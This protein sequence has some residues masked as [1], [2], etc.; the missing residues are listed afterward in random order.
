MAI[1]GF[2]FASQTQGCITASIHAG[3][4]APANSIHAG[5]LSH[6]ISYIN[7]IHKTVYKKKLEYLRILP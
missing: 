3:S 6:E 1:L 4:A 2:G 5:L 7:Y